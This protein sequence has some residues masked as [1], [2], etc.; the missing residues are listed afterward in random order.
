MRHLLAIP[1]LLAVLWAVPA[2][3][4]EPT[5]R[6]RTLFADANRL[7]LSSAS[8]ALLEDRLAAVRALLEDAFDA[9]EAAA[10]ALG[11][12]WEARTPAERDELVRLYADLVARAYLAWLGS[13]ARVHG[14]G[15]EMTFESESVEGDRAVV[16]TTLETRAA[17]DVAIDYRMRRRDGRWAVHDVV[18]DGLS[19]AGSYRAQFQRVMQDG[20]AYPELLARLRDKASEATLIAIARSRRPQPVSA[21][22]P[23]VRSLVGAA[24]ASAPAPPPPPVRLASAAPVSD[25]PLVERGTLGRAAHRPDATTVETPAAPAAAVVGPPPSAPSPAAVEAARP[26]APVTRVPVTRR[27]FWIQVGAF[28]DTELAS[29]LVERLRQYRVMVATRGRP[30][31]A[32]ARVLVGPFEDRTAAAA[33]LRELVAA[34]HRAFVAFE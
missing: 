27:W 10:F 2:A 17:G 20:G 4:G 21:A 26:P 9:R 8:E 16:G 1:L 24:A 32:L 30:S 5:E 33:A 25:T 7:F 15:V 3:A 28:R 11:R 19:L 29:R 22:L 14:S 13:H 12:E 18:V 31:G 6:L 23:Q 34:G